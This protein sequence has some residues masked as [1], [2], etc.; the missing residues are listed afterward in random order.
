M[1][2]TIDYPFRFPRLDLTFVHFFHRIRRLC[3]FLLDG[4][5]GPKGTTPHHTELLSQGK[6]QCSSKEWVIQNETVEGG[7]RK[8][9][10]REVS[11]QRKRK[12][13]ERERE[14]ERERE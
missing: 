10:N 14:S 12:E 7:V 4:R 1:L 11:D 6:P 9:S 5:N 3:V 2:F 8:W 13:R